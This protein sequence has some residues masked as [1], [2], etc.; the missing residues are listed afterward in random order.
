GKQVTLGDTVPEAL[1][2]AIRLAGEICASKHLGRIEKRDALDRLMP[3]PKGYGIG[4]ADLVIEAGPEKIGIK[5]KIYDGLIERMKDGAI[6][7]SNTSSLSVDELSDHAP[8]GARF[9][10]LHFFNPVS[11]IDLVEVIKG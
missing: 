8:D 9:A 11:R 10:G 3:D 7:V 2:S 4:A 6:L 5:Q 1:G